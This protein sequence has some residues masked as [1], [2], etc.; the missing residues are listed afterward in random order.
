MEQFEELLNNT[1]VFPGTDEPR[2]LT[3]AALP[4]VYLRGFF[5][6]VQEAMQLHLKTAPLPGDKAPT[7]V[8]DFPKDRQGNPDTSYD[9]IQWSVLE[10]VPAGMDRSG[11]GRVPF[12]PLPREVIS[13]PDKAGYFLITYGWWEWAT[14]VFTVF[15]K[16]NARANELA[17]WFHF[18][19]MLYG[20][21]LDFMRMRGVNKLQFMG[22]GRDEEN[23]RFGGQTLYMRPLKYA[24]RLEVLN[25]AEVKTLETVEFNLGKNPIETITLPKPQTLGS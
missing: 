20:Q 17:E 4:A 16:S 12:R 7:L 9:V 22:R 2:Q 14:V 13:H 6:A 8:E 21:Q 18:F 25:T 3:R 23:E 19:M 24:F 1:P 15:A 10:S 11:H 5:K